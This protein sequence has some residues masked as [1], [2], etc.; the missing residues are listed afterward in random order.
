ML[1]VLPH[2]SIGAA[3]IEAASRAQSLRPGAESWRPC[4]QG[5][6]RLLSR[7]GS[8]R[9]SFHPRRAS[10]WG[11]PR[12]WRRSRFRGSTHRRPSARRCQSAENE[13]H[14]CGHPR[15]GFASPT[16]RPARSRVHGPEVSPRERQ[17]GRP[18]FGLT[19]IFFPERRNPTEL[20]KEGNDPV[21]RESA[22]GPTRDR[23]RVLLSAPR[24]FDHRDSPLA[25]RLGKR[26]GARRAIA[27]LRLLGP[28]RFGARLRRRA[29]RRR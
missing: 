11:P 19:V 4:R 16:H 2:A 9:R 7:P 18:D 15:R 12:P 26:Q 28:Q 29:C 8:R 23:D 6:L 22:S 13:G 10:G 1:E 21:E 24:A 14:L 25:S 27:F 3:S 20:P 5:S 17:A